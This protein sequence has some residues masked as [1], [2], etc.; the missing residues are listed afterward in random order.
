MNFIPLN[1]LSLNSW[2]KI[3]FEGSRLW[4][5]IVDNAMVTREYRHIKIRQRVER[6]VMMQSRKTVHHPTHQ[7]KWP[8]MPKLKESNFGSL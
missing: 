1:S 4:L 2:A 3:I 8:N 5:I 7:N 6:S